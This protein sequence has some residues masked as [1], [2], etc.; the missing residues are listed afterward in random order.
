MSLRRA[1]PSFTYFTHSSARDTDPCTVSPLLAE[2]SINV[3]YN[4]IKRKLTFIFH[5]F[6]VF[7]RFYFFLKLF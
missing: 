7:G 1:I 2:D 5:L 4:V 6:V 3:F